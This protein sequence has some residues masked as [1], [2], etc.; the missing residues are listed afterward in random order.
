MALARVVAVMQYKNT[1]T[2]QIAPSHDHSEV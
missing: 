2:D 1:A